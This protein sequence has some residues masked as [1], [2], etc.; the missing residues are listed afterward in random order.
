M[1]G[2]EQSDFSCDGSCLCYMLSMVSD[3]EFFLPVEKERQPLKQHEE[4]FAKY[5]YN[6]YISIYVHENIY[7]P[8][9][10]YYPTISWSTKNNTVP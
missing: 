3:F 9:V 2:S 5:V 1:F 8:M 7:T 10:F 6:A 4:T